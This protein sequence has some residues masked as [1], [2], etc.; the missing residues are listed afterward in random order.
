MSNTKSRR[1][2]K[3]VLTLFYDDKLSSNYLYC[4]LKEEEL[5]SFREKI[6]KH[7]NKYLRGRD[8]SQKQINLLRDRFWTV[9]C[10]RGDCEYYHS[11][12]VLDSCIECTIAN[13][14][15]KYLKYKKNTSD[16]LELDC[17]VC[18]STIEKDETYTV[19]NCNH[20]FHNECIN[21]WLKKHLNCPCCRDDFK[22]YLV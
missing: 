11:R 21:K 13:K 18:I 22:K 10:K 1:T 3:D 12:F 8:L 2:F 16:V 20:Y 14:Q 4:N 17:V 7:P 6:Y 5:V 15:Q 19:L 9:R